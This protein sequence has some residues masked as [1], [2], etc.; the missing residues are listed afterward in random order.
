MLRVQSDRER[1]HQA[2]IAEMKA[3]Q[4]RQAQEL[5]MVRTQQIQVHDGGV[6]IL[7]RQLEEQQQLEKKHKL[8]MMRQ[9][10]QQLSEQKTLEFRQSAIKPTGDITVSATSATSVYN[11]GSRTLLQSN[12]RPVSPNTLAPPGQV[13]VPQVIQHQGFN[14]YPN[15]YQ[16]GGQQGYNQPPTLGYPQQGQYPPQQSQYPPQQGL[17]QQQGPYPPQQQMYQQPPYNQQGWQAQQGQQGYQGPPPQLSV[18]Q[19][20]PPY[21]GGT[22][23][24][25]NQPQN[26]SWQQQS[27]NSSSGPTNP[28]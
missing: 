21:Q 16:Q 11:S 1:I 15:D 12:V 13:P 10:E 8:D 5:E 19:P 17:Y 4:V 9:L 2:Q 6:D 14:N 28:Q 3:L 23:A 24:N 25:W 22:Q 7:K 26:N 20:Q 18:G 27:Q